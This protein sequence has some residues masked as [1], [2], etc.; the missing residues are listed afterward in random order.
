MRDSRLPFLVGLALLGWACVPR[1]AAPVGAPIPDA[2]AAATDLIAATALDDRSQITFAWTLDES[3]SR[4]RGRGVLRVQPSELLRLDLFGPR[5]ESY[6]AAAMRGDE[7]RLPVGARTEDVAIPSASLLWAGLGVVRPPTGATLDA[8]T[9]TDDAT[10]LRYAGPNGDSYEYR[11]TSDPVARLT[12]LQRLGPRGPIETVRV[13]R[14]DGGT[15]TRATY[16]D[17]SA[18]R[19]LTL[20]IESIEAVDPF[21]ESIWTP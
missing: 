15:I 5:N 1:N 13:E 16:R 21:P 11:V 17:W 10:I 3:G 8:A 18:F 4:V 2:G 14:G 6:L 20:V 9:T 12:Q 19:D 7:V